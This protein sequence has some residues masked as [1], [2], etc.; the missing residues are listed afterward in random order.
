M[1][2][3]F[4]RYF[5]KTIKFELMAV[6]YDVDHYSD[7][8]SASRSGDDTKFNTLPQQNSVVLFMCSPS[9]FPSHD[10]TKSQILFTIDDFLLQARVLLKKTHLKPNDC[11]SVSDAEH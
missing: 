9:T 6:A 5:N 7:L 10:K 1:S 3:T 2:S 8:E 11:W 4:V